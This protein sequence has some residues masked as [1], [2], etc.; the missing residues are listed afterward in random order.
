MSLLSKD[1]ILSA[2]DLPFE[3]VPVPEWGGHVRIRTLT[4]FERDHFE[5]SVQRDPKGK[6]NL[7]NV[8]ARLLALCLIDEDGTRMFAEAEIKALGAKSA[9]VLDHLLDIAKKLSGLTD[10]DV[11]EMAEG[12]TPAP[13]DDSASDSQDT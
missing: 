10:E 7:N 1:Q 9:K 3:D 13:S 12:F 2:D 8:R 4:G 6:R 11:E 5:A